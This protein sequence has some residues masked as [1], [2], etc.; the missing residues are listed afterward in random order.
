MKNVDTIV[1]TQ[2][3]RAML[4]YHYI[5]ILILLLS[6]LHILVRKCNNFKYLT[7]ENIEEKGEKNEEEE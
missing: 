7:L 2:L 5:L 1:F 6:V 3:Q 4:E